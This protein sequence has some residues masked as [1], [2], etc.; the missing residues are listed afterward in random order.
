MMEATETYELA[1]LAL[2]LHFNS[3]LLIL[4]DHL[5]RPVFL[6]ALDLGVVDLATDETLGVEDRVLGVGVVRVLSS[7]SDTERIDEP[8]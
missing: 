1:V 3:R 7:I 2:V 6:V 8:G 5:E 4:L